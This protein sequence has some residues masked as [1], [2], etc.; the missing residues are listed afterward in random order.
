M[1]DI[2]RVIE[3]AIEHRLKHFLRDKG[4]AIVSFPENAS[5]YGKAI[6]RGQIMI[7]YRSSSFKTISEQPITSAMDA[8]F[9]VNFSLQ[10]LRSHTGAYLLLDWSRF[11]LTGFIPI[12]GPVKGL[13]ASNERIDGLQENGNWEYT[14]TWTVPLSIV[15]G[16]DGYSPLPL[17]DIQNQP[18]SPPYVITQ[19]VTGIWRNKVGEVPNSAEA[20]LD[21]EWEQAIG[22]AP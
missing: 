14:Q 17:E 21:R 4:C 10:D 2:L 20:R 9:E 13:R 16:Y 12:A 1:P 8:N 3:H 7:G 18:D 22:D 6:P 5:K 19:I 15:A 11:A